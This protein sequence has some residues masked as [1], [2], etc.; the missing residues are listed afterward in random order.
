MSAGDLAAASALYRTGLDIT[1]A[2]VQVDPQDAPALRDQSIFHEKL[3]EAA[4]AGGDATAAVGQYREALAAVQRMVDA[5]PSSV[6][7]RDEL[8]YLTGRVDAA[9]RAA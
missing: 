5:D 4:A 9:E 8:V 1:R 3:A 2:A 6:A 7:A